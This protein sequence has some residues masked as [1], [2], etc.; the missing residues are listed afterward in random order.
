MIQQLKGGKIMS[1]LRELERLFARGKLSRREFLTRV[2]AIGLTAA[3][4]P[5]FLSTPARAATPKNG[6]RFRLGV[7]S[8]ASSDSLDPGQLPSA[9]PQVVHM[10]LRNCLVELD[11]KYRPIP[12]LAENWEPSKDASKW[13]F[14]LRQGIE[15]H[16]GKTM[17]ADDVAFSI[18]YHRGKDSKSS[19]KT[20]VKAVKDIKVEDKNTVTFILEGGSADFPFVLSDYH[21]AIVPAGTTDFEKGMGTG[22]FK[23]VKW[24]P[25]IRALTERNRN[26]WKKGRGHFDE[27]ET[28]FIADVNARTTALK[29]GEIDAMNRCERKT[30]SLLEKMTNIKGINITGTSHCT[31]PMLCDV[32]PYTDN[33]VRMALKL[34]IKREEVLKLVF[35]GYGVL[36]N[37]HPIAPSQRYYA[38]ELPQRHYDPD[39]AKFYMKKAGMLDHTFDLYVSDAAFAGAVDTAV[40]YSESAA[41]AGIKIRVV[42]EP[43]DGYWSNVWMK[44]PWTFSFWG[45]R[46]SEDW[47]FTIGYAEG[48]SWN[49]SHFHNKR[50]NQL[51]KDAR[52]ELDDAKRRKMYVEMQRIVR[53]EGGS[54]IPIFYNLLMAT[55]EKVMFENVAGNFDLD[56]LRCA[57]RWWFA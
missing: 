7:G 43:Q 30:F 50:F 49:E 13:T 5:A 51:L 15:F 11:Y 34:A 32:A 17:D 23:L 4:S 41:K 47:M 29:T 10:Q 53:D 45:G 28:V 35:R 9:A 54:V 6:G 27:V 40:L 2:S 56:G 48:A 55:G 16:N 18:N 33:N 44:K 12:E 24:E 36:G 52:A 57:E 8:G 3:L 39:K 46:P 21:L 38:S 19:A 25:G 20:L 42:R 1:T 14:K 37:D 31:I 26:Y 22:A